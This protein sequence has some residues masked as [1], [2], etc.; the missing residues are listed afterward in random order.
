MDRKIR[1]ELWPFLLFVASLPFPSIFQFNFFSATVYLSD[2]LFLAAAAAWIASYAGKRQTISRSKFYFFL[3]AYPVAVV[4]STIASVDPT[5]SSIKLVG[6]LYLIGVAL[7]TLNTVTSIE[8]LKAVV[9]AW[10]LGAAAALVFSLTGIVLF[11]CGLTDPAQTLVLHP[12]FGSLPP[13]HYP[14]IEGF[15]FYP[16]MFCNFLGV[17]WVFSLLLVSANW[18][19]PRGF[20][21][22]SAALLVVNAFTLTPG[23]GGMFIS[24]AW[25]LRRK[26]FAKRHHVLGRLVMLSGIGIG[27]AFLIAAAV[28]LFAYDRDGIRI[29]LLSGGISPSHR[30]LAWQTA[31][32]KFLQNPVLGNG[33]GTPVAYAIFTDPSGDRHLLA[34]AHNTYISVLGETG[35]VGFF[36]FMGIVGFI[37]VGLVRWRPEDEL[38]QTIKFCSLLALGDAFFYQSFTGSYEDARH[39]WVLF[40]IT[41]AVTGLRNSAGPAAEPL[42]RKYS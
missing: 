22:L 36:T 1:A 27:V 35:L 9:W 23:L 3:A 38:C 19:K 11:Y 17:T 39:L 6:K 40:G 16:A 28:T 31:A 41:A 37:T 30:A 10:I 15:F 4:L 12:I 5:L 2:L 7:L 34:D 32:E 14:R 25:V 24:S 33:V 21:L 42:N 26:L 18:I 8:E 13:G 29:P 20:R